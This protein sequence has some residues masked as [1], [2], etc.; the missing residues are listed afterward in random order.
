MDLSTAGALAAYTYRTG[1]SSGSPASALLQAFQSAS[2]AAAQTAVL[3]GGGGENP[4]LAAL[5]QA[6][7]GF[8]TYQLAAQ[9][10]AGTAAVQALLAST[11]S[12][13][14]L[15]VSSQDGSSGTQTF[16][17]GNVDLAAAL[18]SYA[19]A[20]ALQSGLSPAAAAQQFVQGT[21][22]GLNL[23]A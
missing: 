17:V 22:G 2:S 10:G 13:D 21:N 5:T 7:A 15:L 8:A 3:D 14:A 18:S 6:P 19:Y 11:P 9:A 23:L 12:T 4:L 20:Q 16:P 1:L